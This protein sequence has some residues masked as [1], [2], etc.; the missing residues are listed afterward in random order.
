VTSQPF[1]G[2][3]FTV[4]HVCMGNICRSPMAERLLAAR[5][6]DAFG[7]DADHLVRSHGAGVG[8]WHVGNPMQPA[9]ARQVRRR[10]GS[11]D[12]FAARHL[13][14][15]YIADSDLVLTATAEQVRVVTALVPAAADRTFTLRGWGRLLDGADLS[16]LPPAGHSADVLAARGRAM[17]AAA[18]AV[19]AGQAA[20]GADPVD[21]LPDPYGLADDEFA[22]VADTVD[23]VVT[24]LV[25]VLAGR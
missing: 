19:R 20:S 5:M 10:G 1:T 13:A 11:P 14:A 16:S 23:A 4:L 6:C 3:P 18:H 21:D 8:D 12:G 17:V 9:A 24:R 15:A 2:R 22:A 7:P 25:E